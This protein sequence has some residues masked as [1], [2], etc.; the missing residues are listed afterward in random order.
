L[1]HQVER[2]VASFNDFIDSESSLAYQLSAEQR[3]RLAPVATDAAEAIQH[4]A[5]ILRPL[6]TDLN[7]LKGQHGLQKWS[8]RSWKRVRAAKA[9]DDVQEDL[10][11]IEMLNGS[12]IRELQ[13]SASIRQESLVSVE[14]INTLFEVLC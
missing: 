14:P 8:R 6:G 11:I 3:K 4:I 5:D 2:E 1:T 7:Q 10:K 9:M 12:I 13:I